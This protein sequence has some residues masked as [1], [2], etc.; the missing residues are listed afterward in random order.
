MDR[1]LGRNAY[2]A[3]STNILDTSTMSWTVIGGY[4]IAILLVLF[5]ILLIVHYTIY[6]IFQLQ[7]G[8]PGFIRIPFMQS[9]Q[10]FWDKGKFDDISGNCKVNMPNQAFNWS[11]SLDIS[12]KNPVM[13]VQDKQFKSL[14]RL[15]FN[16]GGTVKDTPTFGDGSIGDIFDRQQTPYNLAIGLLRDTND[17]YISTNTNAGEQGVLLQN[18]PTQTPFRIGVVVMPTYLEVYFNGKLSKTLKLAG[19][20]PDIPSDRPP[21]FMQAL[22]GN[23]TNLIARLGNLITWNQ[24]VSPSVMKYAT[25]PLMDPSPDDTLGANAGSCSSSAYNALDDL[26]GGTLSNMN[27]QFDSL[28]ASGTNAITQ[29]AAAAAGAGATTTTITG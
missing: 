6:P 17:L 9:Q 16:R 19:Q 5:I 22:K 28:V 21:L 4:S 14:F 24:V 10:V 7:A 8:G 1:A 26:T 29:A 25:P 11:M 2:T 12:I 20:I 3:A 23:T 27:V 18:V 15:L 13:T